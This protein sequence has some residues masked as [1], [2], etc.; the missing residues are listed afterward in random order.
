MTFVIFSRLPSYFIVISLRKNCSIESPPCIGTSFTNSCP[1]W[2]EGTYDKFKEWALKQFEV[3]EMDSDDNTEVPV[4]Y[5]KARDIEF[6]KNDL[7]E[8]ILPPL[9]NFGTVRQKQRV[10]RGYIGA[11]YREYMY[12]YSLHYWTQEVHRTIYW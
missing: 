10:V 8:L 9:S 7:G 3:K 11:V 12:F 1:D 2:S 5:C 6:E 4:D